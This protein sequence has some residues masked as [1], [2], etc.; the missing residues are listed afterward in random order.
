MFNLTLIEITGYIASIIVA[1]SLM[2]RSVI[3]LRIL[4][5]IGAILFTFY[6]IIINSFPIASV[7]GFIVLID[8]YYIIDYFTKKEKFQFYF[9][10]YK[11]NFAKKFIDAF[12]ELYG[13][14]IKSFFP[15][16]DFKIKPYH[17]IL[18]FFRNLK[19]A[20]LLIL[21]PSNYENYNHQEDYKLSINIS[22]SAKNMN[23]NKDKSD[24]DKILDKNKNNKYEIN[25]YEIRLDYVTP[26]YRD[27]K[28]GKYLFLENRNIFSKINAKK[29]FI[30]TYNPAHIRYLKKMKFKS[31]NN[32][33]TVWE[34][35]F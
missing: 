11:N 3:K 31:T 6:G 33:K 25:E 17:K 22:K 9:A 20:G 7:N 8:I 19:P 2:S 16:F 14:D 28:I 5:I 27:F 35:I 34:K 30:K 15:D 4:N 24:S 26:E 10:D 29:I 1:L 13:K 12:F 32:K 21:R 18:L 23:L